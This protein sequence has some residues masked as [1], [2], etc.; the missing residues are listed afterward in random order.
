MIVKTKL[1]LARKTT[2]KSNGFWHRMKQTSLAVGRETRFKSKTE[3]LS[4]DLQYGTLY[5]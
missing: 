4:T 1:L 3:S 5:V 2:T